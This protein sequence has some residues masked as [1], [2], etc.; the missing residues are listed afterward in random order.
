MELMMQCH[1]YQSLFYT[2]RINFGGSR[3]LG[4]VYFNQSL[5]KDSSQFR[6]EG[7]SDYQENEIRACAQLLKK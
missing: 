1:V 3:I 6:K 5:V 2:H 4:L 7:V